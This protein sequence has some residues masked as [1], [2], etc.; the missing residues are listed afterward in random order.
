MEQEI[1]KDI[2]GYEGRYQVSNMGQVK[3]LD[4]AIPHSDGSIHFRT[5]QVIKQ[6]KNRLG[7]MNVGLPRD[8]TKTKQF[9]VHRLVAL[10]FIPNP[11][12]LPCVNHKDENKANNS[13]E[14]LEWCTKDYNN[15]YGKGAIQ[16]LVNVKKKN[17]IARAKAVV[18]ID[19]KT[20]KVIARYV[21][22]NE[23]GRAVGGYGANINSCCR[24]IIHTSMGYKWKYV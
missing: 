13:V 14:N 11:N 6:Y 24:G 5:S 22:A 18:Q 23:A 16:R 2:P 7:Y 8:N 15:K 19:P 17:R 1:W 12:N 9:L 10:A 3:S 20:N 21:S 4:R